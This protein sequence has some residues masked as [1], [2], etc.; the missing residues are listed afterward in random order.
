ML[1]VYMIGLKSAARRHFTRAAVMARGRCSWGLISVHRCTYLDTPLL[2]QIEQT[3]PPAPLSFC[4]GCAESFDKRHREFRSTVRLC[5]S[6]KA[7]SLFCA[8][9]Y[10]WLFVVDYG[11]F[12]VDL[13]LASGLAE[14]YLAIRT[15]FS[16]A[17][18]TTRMTS[19]CPPP[20]CKLRILPAAPCTNSHALRSH[21]RLPSS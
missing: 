1:T 7:H 18:P 8:V 9:L 11:R 19:A 4:R 10:G 15:A 14:G 5:G 17:G 21:A 6:D 2:S 12:P 16:K 3:P 20:R 13:L